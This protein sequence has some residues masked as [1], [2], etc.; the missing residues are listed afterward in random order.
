MLSFGIIRFLHCG[1]VI[2]YNEYISVE[3]SSTYCV[4]LA[5]R[6]SVS[7]QYLQVTR[8]GMLRGHFPIM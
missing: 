2:N 1:L 6:A 7:G 3:P 4:K 8:N 5:A